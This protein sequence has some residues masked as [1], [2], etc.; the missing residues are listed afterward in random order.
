MT[1]PQDGPPDAVA[2]PLIDL[3]DARTARFVV[4]RDGEVIC[5]QPD[6]AEAQALT[7]HVRVALAAGAIT[8]FPASSPRDG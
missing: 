5:L 4:V 6:S 2:I 7:E 1:M 3:L 8:A